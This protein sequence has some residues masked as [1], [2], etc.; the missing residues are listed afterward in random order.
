MLKCDYVILCERGVFVKY[1]RCAFIAMLCFATA[2]SIPLSAMATDQPTPAYYRMEQIQQGRVSGDARVNVRK[3]AGK[4]Y[5]AVCRMSAGDV[6][7]VIGEKGDWWQISFEGKTGYVLKE[8]LNV[9]TVEEEVAVIVEAPLEAEVID[10]NPPV[11]LE[12]R[13]EYE[14]NGT[15][16]SNVPLISVTA[17]IYDLRQLEVERSASVTFSR[18]DGVYE[19]NLSRMADDLSFRKLEPGE[20]QLIIRSSS[21]NEGMVVSETSFYVYG[22]CKDVVSMTSA[23]S[24]DVAHGDEDDMLD[25]DYETYWEFRSSDDAITVDLPDDKTPDGLSLHWQQAPK[26]STVI[27]YDADGAELQTIHESNPGN[28]MQ[29]YY[30]LDEA[31]RK[32]RITTTDKDNGM[33]ELRVYE[34]GKVPQMVQ[35]W[36]PLPE[37]IDMMII[38]AHKNDELLSIGGSMSFA[39]VEG[40]TCAVVYMTANSRLRYA[41]GL[42]GMW[43]AGNRY[44]PIFLTYKDAKK[45]DYKETVDLWGWDEALGDVV[46][47]IRKYKPDVVVTHDVDG[48]Y[49]HNQHILT[50]ALTQAAVEAALD[51]EQYSESADQYGVWDTPKLYIHL[52]P[53]GRLTLPWDEPEEQLGGY[54]INQLTYAAFEKH[55]SQRKYYSMDGDG[56]TYDCTCFG[57]A[58]S[59]VGEDI[60]KN[61]FFENL[62]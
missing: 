14:L 15:V 3:G 31:T 43:T 30:E 53:E 4:D 19:Y 61:S 40:K 1:I 23:C 60:E 16:K 55:W 6:C 37:K 24:V 5:D 12:Y 35:K 34:Q 36:E 46:E 22:E 18:D 50:C 8:L 41:E 42:D 2:F 57:L 45:G 32:I 33:V 52:Y 54:T 39:A 10:L 28:M 49:G 44:H 13:N 20:K 9:T 48:E 21:S 47:L 59:T 7:T 26:D 62:D 58:R 27:L 25:Y 38:V 11:L 17:E 29:M 51:A 56:K